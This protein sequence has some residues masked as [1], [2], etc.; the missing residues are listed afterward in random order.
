MR[1]FRQALGSNGWLIDDLFCNPL[2][3]EGYLNGTKGLLKRRFSVKIIKRGEERPNKC[4]K[5]RVSLGPYL[6]K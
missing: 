1:A 2:S 4:G 5:R 3:E 6:V